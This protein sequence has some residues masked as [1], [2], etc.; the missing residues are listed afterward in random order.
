MVGKLI[1]QKL[2]SLPVFSASDEGRILYNSTNKR[3]YVATDE[4]W[5]KIGS[6]AWGDLESAF[7][8]GGTLEDG[9]LYSIDT[10]TVPLTGYLDSTPTSGDIISF[11]DKSGT[12]S[13]NDFYLNGNGNTI[14]G[15]SGKSFST[16][17]TIASLV[18]E[19]SEWKIDI[20]GLSTGSSAASG[21]LDFDT[22]SEVT[23]MESTDKFVIL[24]VTDGLNKKLTLSNWMTNL[25]VDNNL[26]VLATAADED[27][28]IIYD[29]DAGLTK[30]ILAS[31]VI[32][33]GGGTGSGINVIDI[34]AND[35]LLDD[36]NTGIEYG[37]VFGIY[38]TVD[39]STISDGSCWVTAEFPASWSTASDLDIDIAYSLSGNDPSKTVRLNV[40]FWSLI[41][42]DTPVSTVSDI[43]IN[44]D[45]ATS[46]TNIAKYTDDALT[47]VGNAYLESGMKSFAIKLTRDI[48]EDDYSGTL[49]L[50]SVKISQ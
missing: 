9:Y 12:F 19:G 42:T 3:P 33:E 23:A 28:F 13:L 38:K 17:E 2:T 34:R 43:T 49:Q 30:K 45:I 22:L 48:S 8:D 41:E 46:S 25:N 15:L 21:S 18:F 16:N 37:S 26:N 50:I 47:S 7:N 29:V 39:F 36:T 10:S 24:D 35:I 11:Y 40:D 5:K 6:G 44:N 32:S 20:G 31:N 1:L 4:R 14:S 27:Y